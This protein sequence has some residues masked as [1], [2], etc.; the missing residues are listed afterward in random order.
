M[1]AF[2]YCSKCNKNKPLRDFNKRA[3]A[4]HRYRSHCKSC[5]SKENV[6]RAQI[7]RGSVRKPAMSAEQRKENS[8]LAC[9]KYNA[10]SKRKAKQAFYEANRRA[11]KI[12]ATPAWLSK[13]QL[14]GIRVNYEVAKSLTTSTGVEFEVDHIIPLKGKHVCGLHVPWNLQV[15]VKEANNKKS[16][17]MV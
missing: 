9:K 6:K 15:M 2:K 1:S 4:P 12:M 16:N 3:D 11:K 5:C 10:T 13:Y 17:R 8:R 14:E 7:K